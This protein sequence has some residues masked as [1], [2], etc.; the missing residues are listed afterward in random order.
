MKEPYGEGLASHTGSELCAADRANRE[1]GQV[2]REALTG[3]QAG[4]VFSR[5]IYESEGRRR[6]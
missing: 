2:R 3:A 4:G 6:P 1:V 5:V